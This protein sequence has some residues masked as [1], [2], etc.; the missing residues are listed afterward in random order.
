MC[1]HI[2]THNHILCQNAQGIKA[3]C[4]VPLPHTKGFWE[5]CRVPLHSLRHPKVSKSKRVMEHMRQQS[6]TFSF[7]IDLRHQVLT[8]PTLRSEKQIMHALHIHFH[9]METRE[10]LK[11]VLGGLITNVSIPTK[12]NL[13]CLG[14]FIKRKFCFSCPSAFHL[15]QSAFRIFKNQFLKKKSQNVMHSLKKTLIKPRNA[16]EVNC[17]IKMNE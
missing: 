9:S 16:K 10:W 4:S 1:R 8:R 11:L 17:C 5:H 14:Y 3:S 13:H 12:E 7:N 6:H 2:H 15:H